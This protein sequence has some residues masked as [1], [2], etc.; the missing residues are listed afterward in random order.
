LYGNDTNNSN[1]GKDIR[2]GYNSRSN[3]Y[4]NFV[5]QGVETKLLM[6]DL[7]LSYM[8]KHNLFVDLKFGYRRTL[9]PLPQFELNTSYISLGIRL[10][11]NTRNYDF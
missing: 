10:N 5:G 4:G 3:D 6:G 11:M 2:L 9:S 7:M 8:P 1:W